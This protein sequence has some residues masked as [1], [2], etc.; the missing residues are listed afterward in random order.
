MNPRLTPEG[1]DAT[2]ETDSTAPLA[3][4]VVPLVLSVLIPGLWWTYADRPFAFRPDLVITM[5]GFAALVGAI[6]AASISR[7]FRYRIRWSLGVSTVVLIVLFQW[8][9]LTSAGSAVADAVGIG[10]L[11]DVVPVA[12]GGAFIWLTV[13]RAHEVAF[14][15]IV[16][17]AVAIA[18]VAMSA[19][20]FSVAAPAPQQAVATEATGSRP[21]LLLVLDGYGRA[22]FI[23]DEYGYDNSPFL[24]QLEDRGFVIA[25][26]ATAN[27]SYTYA[28]VSSMLNLDYVFAA[29]PI[30]G[31]QHDVMRGAL[32]GANGLMAEMRGAGYRIAYVEN[33]WGGSQ[34][35]S[36]VDWC[37]RDGLVRRAAWNLG[38]MTILAPVFDGLFRDPFNSLS[39]DHLESLPDLLTANADTPTFFFVHLLLPHAP[40]VLDSDCTVRDEDTFSNWGSSGGELR[41]ARRNRYT[42]QVQCVNDL[43]VAA[44]DSFIAVHPDAVVM[45]TAD[46]GPGS[47]LDATLSYD[48]QSSEVLEERMPILGAYRVPG[49]PDQPYQSI[50]PVNG[51]RLVANCAAGSSLALLPDRNYWLDL[52]GEGTVTEITALVQP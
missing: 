27:Y 13:R 16:G 18:V 10:L 24:D 8:S 5:T 25:P 48:Q 7:G 31:D 26:H 9:S 29:G 44:I 1:V 12:I 49:C 38:Q 46:H 30:Q 52:D 50:T 51:A 22:D 4:W 28:A 35:G 20:A 41:Q 43:V 37:I 19:S 3:I 14:V 6:L 17:G 45:I 39:V 11:G 2:A 15:A 47:L 36:G 33:A 32:T 34:C 21:T 42:D 40:L 23:Q